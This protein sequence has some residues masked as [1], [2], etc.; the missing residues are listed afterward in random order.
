MNNSL[1]CILPALFNNS[2]HEI[3]FI[4]MLSVIAKKKKLK[5]KF[6]LPKKNT[7][8][9]AIPHK[10]ELFG[11]NDGNFIIKLFYIIGN[12]FILINRLKRLKKNDLVYIDGYSFYFLISLI[13]YLLINGNLNKLVIWVRYPYDS[14]IKKY[15]FK[16]FIY[17]F[18]IDS[19]RQL[20]TITE[21]SKLAR[22]LNKR[23]SI[24]IQTLPSHHKI[25]K[26]YIKNRKFN[27]SKINNSK[28]NN[29][30]INI[31]CPGSFRPEK[32]GKNLVNFLEHNIKNKKIFALNI[33]KKFSNFYKNIYKI[34]IRFFK[35]DL[36]KSEFI[37]QINNC[38]LVILPYNFLD[39]KLRTS[40]IF[41]ETISMGKIVFITSNT[42]MSRELKKNNL[43]KLIVKDWN[44]ISIQKIIKIKNDKLVRKNL[45]KMKNNYNKL[46]GKENLIKEF[47]RIVK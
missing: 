29:S 31:L 17:L 47:L 37:N 9:I 26:I 15:I 23:F 12:Y 27:N 21:N 44:N 38:H 45:I 34:N 20:I 7:L 35:N 33:D 43:E 40:G 19:S 24:K 6:I 42:I 22:V 39:Y 28:I 32:Y 41:F 36:K 25:E 14:I 30:K 13:L 8:K 10:K 11:S 18:N 46:H 4:D 1:V 3:D 5:I 16:F 2:G